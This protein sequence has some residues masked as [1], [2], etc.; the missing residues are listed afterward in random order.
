MES[1]PPDRF[2]VFVCIRLGIYGT[3]QK[4]LLLEDCFHSPEG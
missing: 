4:E 3:Q 2:V 1:L